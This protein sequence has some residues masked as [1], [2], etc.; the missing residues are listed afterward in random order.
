MKQMAND[1]SYNEIILPTVRD[2]L[3]LRV[4]EKDKSMYR[5]ILVAL[6]G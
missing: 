4:E 1:S 6:K 5:S 2:Q 3:R